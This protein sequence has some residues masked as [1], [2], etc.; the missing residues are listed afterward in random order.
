MSTRASATP[1]IRR[2]LL[3]FLLPPLTALLLVGVFVDYRAALIFARKTYDQRLTDAALSLAAQ[4]AAG[5]DELQAQ[6]P[7]QRRLPTSGVDRDPDFSYSITGPHGRLIAG[8]PQLHNAPRS[9]SNPSFADTALAG[10][11]V[12][13]AS[14]ELPTA[15]GTITVNIAGPDDSRTGPARFVLGSTWLIG[16]IQLD[17][18]LLLV[19][20]GVHFGLKPLLDVRRDI[21]AR[22]ARELQP[23]ELANVPAEV[24]PL[25]EGLN[26]LF[27]MLTEA[28]RAQRQFVADTAHQLRT[29]IAG[30]LGHLDV[31]MREPAA[32]ALQDRLASLHEGMSRLAHSAN[33]LLA[34]ARAE[35][36]MNLA[37]RFETVDVKGVVERVLERN[38]D[39]SIES[40]HDLGAEAQPAEVT[41]SVRLL[42]D[43]LGNLVDN[44]LHYTPAGGHITVRCGS[45]DGQSYLEVEDDGPGIAPSERTRVRERFYRSPGSSGHG[46]GLGLAIVDEISR[47]HEANL[48][49]DSGA[50]GRGT[51]IT[52]SFRHSHP[53]VATRG[54]RTK[55]SRHGDTHVSSDTHPAGLELRTASQSGGV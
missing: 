39:R 25:V 2:R 52:V 4:L 36:A 19:W 47:L 28:A 50:N 7:T 15:T 34:L 12:R 10:K 54:R 29:P 33:Q 41:G 43:L 23:L 30:L 14:Y 17:I 6:L 38:I 44:A 24:R 31:L 53:A 27:E 51:R 32:A 11:D 45:R 40:Q 49:I 42:E 5:G 3:I 26:M 46:C 18:T 22:S 16:F 37:D 9:G 8:N 13:V 35:P 1:S 20:I 55:A 48:T 21:E